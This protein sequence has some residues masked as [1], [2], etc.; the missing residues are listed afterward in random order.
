MLDERIMTSTHHQCHIIT[1]AIAD[2]AKPATPESLANAHDCWKP[3]LTMPWQDETL[4][5]VHTICSS[6]PT[7]S[8]DIILCGECS[9]TLDIMWFLS[10]KHTIA[11]WDSILGL[12]QNSGRGQLRRA[13]SSPAGN[14]YGALRLPSTGFFANEIGSLVIGFL[15]ANALRELGYNARIKWPNDILIDDK[16]VGGILLEERNGCLV[17]GVGLNV[18]SFPPE[19]DLRAEWAIPAGSLCKKEQ[20]VS[21]LQLW[22]VLV[23]SIH[24]CYN[25]QVVHY[26]TAELISSVERQLAWLGQMVFVHGHGQDFQS[27]KLMGISS[28]GGLILRCPNGN[29]TLHNGSISLRS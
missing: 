4:S 11:Q 23:D 13:W 2:I 28:D 15:L 16:K 29:K 12:S 25:A 7:A 19:S 8:A 24:F 20:T 6:L 21:L 10:E 3:L 26:T 9:S 18:H 22:Q 27:G 5:T 14:L 1:D 17:A